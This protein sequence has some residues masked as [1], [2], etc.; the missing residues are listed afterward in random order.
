MHVNPFI[1]QIKTHYEIDH[2]QSTKEKPLTLSQI[3]FTVK[4]EPLKTLTF[5]SN[6]CTKAQ[7]KL[8][9]A[10]KYLYLYESQNL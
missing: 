8:R 2:E 9:M 5:L 1:C 7:N 3:K 4:K 10:T 6:Q